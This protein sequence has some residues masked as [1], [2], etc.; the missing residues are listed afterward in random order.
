MTD[1][2]NTEYITI[3]KDGVFVGGKPA[4][5]FHG[6]GIYFLDKIKANF[7]ALRNENPEVQELH[8][9]A[10]ETK[11]IFA[12]KGN[13]VGVFGKNAWTCAKM[14][15]GR[16][17]PWVFSSK[18]RSASGCACYCA[19]IC[20]HSICHNPSL[21]LAML[22]FV[23]KDEETNIDNK[24]TEDKQKEKYETVSVIKKGIYKITIEKIK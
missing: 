2:S 8:V 4:T 22:K 11:G 5:T 24:P 15:D 14:S 6:K 1:I 18:F 3:N 19:S 16:L 20:S 21:R 9:G 12:K 13:P 17:G 23:E 7:A 10:F